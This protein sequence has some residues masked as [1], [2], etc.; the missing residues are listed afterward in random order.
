MLL[1]LGLLI[2]LYAQQPPAGQA[3]RRRPMPEP[4]NLQVL[5]APPSELM[6]IMRAYSAALGVRCNFCHVQGDFASDENPHKKIARQ[7]IAMTQDINHHFEDSKTHVTCYTCH[8]GQEEP[9]TEPS[10]QES[11][12]GPEHGH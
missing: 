11:S 12:P 10:A 9:K 4:K 8:R 3:P 6:P 7:M 5:K 2:P 1:V